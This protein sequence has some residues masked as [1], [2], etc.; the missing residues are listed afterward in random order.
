M[1]AVNFQMAFPEVNSIFRARHIAHS[2]ALFLLYHH[3]SALAL[4]TLVTL[5]IAETKI[6][7]IWIY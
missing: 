7:N 2:L 1:D 5:D 4:K 6:E 3:I